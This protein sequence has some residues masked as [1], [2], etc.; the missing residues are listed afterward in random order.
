MNI[1]SEVPFSLNDIDASWLTMALR[2]GGVLGDGEVTGFTHKIIGEET[3]FLGEVAILYLQYSGD[4]SDAPSTLVLKIPTALKNRVMGQTIGVYEKE[5]RFYSSLRK[6]LKIRSPKHY[7]SALSAADDPDVTLERMEGLNK[8]PIW[9][10]KFLAA[11]VTLIIGLM[12]R[13][14][15]L[16]I[17]DVSYLRLGDQA[18]GCSEADVEKALDT[19]ALLH[20]QYWGSDEL[21]KMSWIAPLYTTAKIM[22]MTYLQAVDK[23]TKANLEH[24]SAR[25]LQL[26]EWLKDNGIRLTEVLGEHPRTLL[27]GDF[28]L[29]N[30]CFD[31]NVG[32]VLLLD[33]QTMLSGCAAVDLAYFLSA[34]LPLETTD[35]RIEELLEYYRQGLAKNGIEISSDRLHWLYEV[36]MLSMLHKI[37]PILFQEQLDLGSERGPEIMRDWIEKTY[38]KLEKVDFENILE[39]A[40]GAA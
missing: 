34:A 32:E 35:E 2:E 38:K 20:A 36:S 28:R 33:W 27:H 3:G 21:E 40:P 12:P 26:I 4:A 37:A 6:D 22:H 11:I 14:Y 8:L 10:I 1:Q 17:E 7:Y 23:Y 13:R 31:D 16:L 39:Q 30:L 24:L 9:L 15:V 19:M 29:D 5:I 18:K 25:Q